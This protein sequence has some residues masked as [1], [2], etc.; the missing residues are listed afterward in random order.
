[1]SSPTRAHGTRNLWLVVAAREVKVKL[2]DRAFLIGTLVSLLLIVGLIGIQAWLDTRG[3]EHTLAVSSAQSATLA[4][5]VATR[6]SGEDDTTVEVEELTDDAARQAVLDEEVDAWLRAPSGDEG[7]TLVTRDGPDGDLRDLVG[8]VLRDQALVD[9]LQRADTSLEE[10]AA[11][12]AISV[13]QLEGDAE[14]GE[15]RDILGFAFAFLFYLSAVMFGM[16]LASSV[17]EEKQ[18]RIVEMI[19]AAVPLRQLLAGKIAGNTALALGQLVTYVGVGMIALQFTD[20]GGLLSELTVEVGWFLLFFLVGF[21]ALACMWAVAGAL[22]SRTEDLQHTTSSITMLLLAMFFGALFLDGG[23]AEV[24]SFIPPLSAVLMPMR[25][26]DG[27]SAWWEPVAAL[28]LLV[29][30]AAGLILAGERLYR[31]ALLQTGGRLSLRAAWK[32]EE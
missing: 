17:V 1:M 4:E 7:W 23:I 13:E 24:A 9:V 31:R 11:A 14:L 3:A 25:V 19:A 8:G 10:I 32:L 29:V 6:A 26:L 16:T 15:L 21:V 2:T 28:A 30:L 22:A 12:S 27:T 18:S 5:D 20:Y